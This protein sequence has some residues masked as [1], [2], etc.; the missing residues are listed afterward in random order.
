MDFVY[1]DS[2]KCKNEFLKKKWNRHDGASLHCRAP[3]Q[4]FVSRVEI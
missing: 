1:F 4:R 3:R 2:A